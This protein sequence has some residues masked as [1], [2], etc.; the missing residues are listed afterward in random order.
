MTLSH[1]SQPANVMLD[2]ECITSLHGTETILA[3]C[4]TKDWLYLGQHIIMVDLWK[5]YWEEG[6]IRDKNI[7]RIEARDKKLNGGSCLWL[8]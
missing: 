4:T 8:P 6:N 2:I 7:A 5:M 3:Q 1:D